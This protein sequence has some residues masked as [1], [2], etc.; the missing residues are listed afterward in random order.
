M[1]HDYFPQITRQYVVYVAWYGIVLE[2]EVSEP[3]RTIFDKHAT[4][5]RM[6][7]HYCVIYSILGEVGKLK[8]GKWLLNFL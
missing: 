3:T 4:V 7:R 8:Y 2:S 5:T 6:Y 1:N